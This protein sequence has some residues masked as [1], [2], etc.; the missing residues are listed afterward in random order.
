MIAVRREGVSV[1]VW[2]SSRL[3]E[4]RILVVDD[5]SGVRAG[6]RALLDC[7]AGF[8]VAGEAVDGMEAVLK[9]RELRP[10]VVLMDL[11]LPRLDGV[12]ATARIRAEFPDTRI[13]A[14]T[15]SEREEDLARALA[16]GAQSYILKTAERAELIEAIRSAAR[17]APTR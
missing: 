4:L 17:E 13:V 9:F 12:E 6:V 7:E 15:I 10:D 1:C 16:A 3:R 11:C 8:S 2:R 5:H 14:W